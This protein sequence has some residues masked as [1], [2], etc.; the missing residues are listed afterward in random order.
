MS[1]WDA[2]I[3]A[4]PSAPPQRKPDPPRPRG[5]RLKPSVSTAQSSDLEQSLLAAE[6]EVASPQE[7]A[8]LSRISSVRLVSEADLVEEEARDRAEAFQRINQ[9]VHH[10]RE[11]FSDLQ[12]LVQEQGES[13][14]QIEG[15][16][17]SAHSRTENAVDQLLKAASYQ[18]GGFSCV[19]WA[20]A[21]VSGILALAAFLAVIYAKIAL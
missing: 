13:V 1:L 2:A 4:T 19:I 14:S 6:Q 20:L 3:S 11:C 9:D 5:G 12:G 8:L 21:I 10:I 18:K 17:E 16:I 7:S 15:D